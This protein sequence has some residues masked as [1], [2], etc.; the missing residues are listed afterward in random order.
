MK[1]SEPDALISFLAGLDLSL[2]RV[3]Y[4]TPP[5]VALYAQ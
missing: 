3:D 1:A 5:K 4:A 2:A